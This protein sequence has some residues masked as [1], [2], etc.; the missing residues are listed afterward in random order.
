[1]MHLLVICH[2][3]PS[4]NKKRSPTVDTLVTSQN[5][6]TLWKCNKLRQL[7]SKRGQT[8]Y[9]T[10]LAQTLVKGCSHPS[11]YSIYKVICLEGRFTTCV[12]PLPW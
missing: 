11:P 9:H 12:N 5:G 8:A 7:I 1:M 10:P 6:N 4:Q 3:F 2:G